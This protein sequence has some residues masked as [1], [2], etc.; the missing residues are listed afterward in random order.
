VLVVS[1]RQER[2]LGL[3][4]GASGYLVKPVRPA[5]V[6]DLICETLGQPAS[7]PGGARNLGGEVLVVDDDD[8]LRHLLVER[9][10]ADGLRARGAADG[11]E[12]LALIAA[13]RPALVLLDLLMPEVDGWEVLR[14]LRADPATAELPVVV[15]SARDGAAAQAAGEDLHV[16][17]FVG[18]PFDLGS[19][20]EEIENVLEAAAPPAASGANAGQAGQAGP[21][22]VGEG[23]A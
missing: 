3:R 15:L 6:K 10:Q 14:R 19:L 5:R 22:G 23:A 21:A 7:A 1:V 4:L 2:A 8:D 18:K 11:G 16:V 13:R 9:L 12:A 20:L 17:D